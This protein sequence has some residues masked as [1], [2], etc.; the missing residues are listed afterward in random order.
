MSG[1]SVSNREIPPK[2]KEKRTRVRLSDGRIS[3]VHRIF[4]GL[5]VTLFIVL[6]AV[7]GYVLHGWSWQDGLYMV[8]IT[9]SG[10]GYGEVLPVNTPYLR[11]LTI[12]LIVCGYV[13][14]IYTVGGFAQL[15]I[16]GE[17]RRILGVKRMQKEIDRT[18]HHVIICGFGRMGTKLAEALATHGKPLIVIDQSQA[19]IDAARGLGYLALQGNATEEAILRAAGVERASILTTVLSDDVCNLFITITAHDLNPRL[20]ILARAEQTSTIKKLRQV[21]A[22]NVILPASIGADLLANM[23]L[24][25]SAESLINQAELQEGLNHDLNSLGLKLDELEIQSGS[26]LIGGTVDQLKDIGDHRCLIVAVRSAD[27]Q[28]ALHPDSDHLLRQ[29]D[30]VVILA[31]ED[32]IAHFCDRYRL[33]SE[34]AAPA[35]SAESS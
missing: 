9:I 24:R 1:K 14:A 27:G 25:P 15:L 2:G 6:A 23:I 20:E 10:V 31:H 7:S 11:A 21:G 8:V 12:A 35:E 26:Q 3:P 19:R 28:V 4:A 34:L 30:C 33:H 16:D 17:L 22:K 32:D 18:H 29:G 13:A 5:L